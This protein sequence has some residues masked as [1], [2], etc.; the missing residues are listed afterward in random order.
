MFAEDYKDVEYEVRKL[1]EQCE[2]WVLKINFNKI[3]YM[4]LEEK[5]RI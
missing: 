5:F 2:K 4:V 1:K 3:E